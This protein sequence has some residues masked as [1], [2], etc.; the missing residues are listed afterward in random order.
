MKRTIVSLSGFWTEWTNLSL[1]DDD[2]SE[3]EQYLMSN[4]N[5]GDLIK[6]SNG[7]RKIRWK[8][9]NR[10]KSGGIRVFYLDLENVC[11]LFLLT[12]ISKNEKENLTKSEILR[13]AEFAT[14]LKKGV[15]K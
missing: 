15:S 5:S 2:L 10:G 11:V 12:L 14:A 13:L 3:F 9:P 8:L 6:G 4:P 1:D 7:I